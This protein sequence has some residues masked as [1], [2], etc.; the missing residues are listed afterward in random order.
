M[1]RHTFYTGNALDVLRTLPSGSV[2]CVVTSPPYFGLRSYLRPDDPCKSFEI[3]TEETPEEYVAHLMEVFREV[4]RVLRDDGTLWLN[5]GDSHADSGRPYADNIIKPKDLIGI[6]WRVAFALQA[7]GWWLRRDIIWHKLNPMPESCQDR[8]TSAHEYVFLL[9]KSE[10]Y[11]FDGE[12]IKEP[13]V[14][15]D[16][17][18]PYGSEGMW[19]MDGRPP[20]KRH[21]GE[22]R[23][24]DMVGQNTYKRN[25]RDV[26]TLPTQP[27][28]GAHFAVFPEALVEPCILAGTSERGCC[29]QC[30]APWTRIVR[31]ETHFA[32]HSAQAGRTAEELLASGKWIGN[33]R[34]MN[35]KMGPVIV[36]DTDGWNP[37]CSCGLEHPVPC[38]VLDPF[39]GSG[40]VS[41]VARR[42]GRDSIYIDLNPGYRDMAI[43]RLRPEQ[44]GLFDPCE[45]DVVSDL[46]L[47]STKVGA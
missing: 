32:G 2:H 24:Q 20:E 34:G 25:K 46:N 13:A 6:P 7:D 33:Q 31:K 9:A 41:V 44:H 45:I 21:G 18:R 23:K 11:F 19:E 40:T 15:N 36:T 35:I 4:R 12:A 3:G 5:L 1:T 47:V 29:P 17:R 10:R 28:P 27:F 43:A 38:T 22:P 8:P 42:L 30:G 39:G 14:T 37:T 26:W 16:I